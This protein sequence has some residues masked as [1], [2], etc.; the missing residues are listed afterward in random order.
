MPFTEYDFSNELSFSLNGRDIRI[1]NPDPT[2]LLSD[3]LRSSEIGLTGTKVACGEG[4]CGACTVM[5]SRFSMRDHRVI[6]QAINSCLRPLCSLDGM[7]VTTIEHAS[8]NPD[9]LSPI[10]VTLAQGNG[11]QCGFCTPGMVMSAH[12]LF[13]S[14][15]QA[16]EQAIEDSL[17]GHICRCTGYRPILQAFRSFGSDFVSGKHYTSNFGCSPLDSPPTADGHR[18]VYLRVFSASDN[19][20]RPLNFTSATHRWIRPIHLQDALELKGHYAADQLVKLVVGNTSLGIYKCDHF[21]VFLDISHIPELQVLQLEPNG[22][23][24]GGTVTLEDLKQFCDVTISSHDDAAVQ[25]LRALSKHLGQIANV[26]VRNIG[27][28]AGNLW[29]TRE[30][31]STD[32]PFP[33]DLDTVL[34]TLGTKVTVASRSYQGDRADFLLEQLPSCEK[35]PKDAILVSLFIPFTVDGELVRT[36]KVATRYQNA[37]A[38]VNAGFRVRLDAQRHVRDIVLA[39][40]GIA[41]Q[42]IR[43]SRTEKFLKEKSWRKELFYSAISVLHSELSE[44]VANFHGSSFFPGAYRRTLATNLFFR[45]FLIVLKDLLKVELPV[46]LQSAC[47]DDNRPLSRARQC[48][49]VD[50]TFAPVGEPFTNHSAFLQVAGRAKYTQDIQLPTGGLYASVVLSKRAKA[51]FYFPKQLADFCANIRSVFPRVIDFITADDVPG[52]NL[53]G[54]GRDEQLFARDEVKFV[55]Q[56]IGIVVAGNMSEARSAASWV[57]EMIQYRKSG[58]ERAVFTIADALAEP[59]GTG[60]FQ[61]NDATSLIPQMIR[62]GSDEAWLDSPHELSPE[63]RTIYGEQSCGGQAQF[64]MET[65]TCLA[66][67]IEQ[68]EITLYSSTQSPVNDQAMTALA[69]GIPMAKVQVEVRR[70]GGGFGGKQFRAGFTSAMTAVAA[71]KLRAPVFLALNRNEDMRMVG[72]RHPFIGKYVLDVTMNG[73]LKAFKIDLVSNGG[74]TL[75]CSF[76]VMNL[77]QQHADCCYFVPTFKTTGRVVRTNLASNTAMR[78]FGV[79]QTTLLVESAIEHAAHEIGVS[80]EELRRKNFYKMSR[81]KAHQTTHFGEGLRFCNIAEIWDSL[82]DDCNFVR[83]TR[84]V[85]EFNRS[86]RWRKRGISAIPLKFGIGFQPRMMDQATA[87]INVFAAD[88]SVL[89]QHGGVEMGQGLNTKIL[90]IASETLRIPVKRITIGD[91]WTGAVPNATATAASISS[92]LHGGAVRSACLI[93]RH[94]LETFCKKQGI[95]DWTN[96]WA[97]LWPS[98]VSGAYAARVDL[99]AEAHYKT[100]YIGDVEF[101]HQYGRAFHYFTY[102]AS[103]SEVEIDALTGATSVIRSD[104]LYDAGRSLNP[105][106]DVGQIEG[107]FVQGIGLMLTEDL[108]FLNDGDLFSDGTWTYKPPC[109][110]TIPVDFRVSLHYASRYDPATSDQDFS[111]VL[112]SKGI[113]EPGLVLATSVFFAV[114]HAI[115]ECRRDAGHTDW[116]E[117]S[118]PATVMQ[119]QKHCDTKLEFLRIP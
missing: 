70:I 2:V 67:P 53:Q 96:K 13:A 45:F 23:R 84:E 63:S 85:E 37:H 19:R 111:A 87:F 72:K 65:Q 6:H 116:F 118:A 7:H 18:S 91:T 112:G 103:C 66:V 81:H 59:S 41:K 94:R 90:Q 74:A 51:Q 114:R 57:S 49:T 102:S 73:I 100:P 32:T 119:V 101:P 55:G 8:G 99:S 104:I 108:Q 4:G 95:L 15:P 39:F 48:V 88:G 107:G 92:D 50:R 61:N 27:S 34:I 89:V 64:Y 109:S 46:S 78:S 83:R 69:L 117:M 60:L 14:D 42:T 21:D 11:S 82:L 31:S 10:Q 68:Q 54:L 47:I 75:D 30:K 20:A 76:P 16:N 71:W 86:S 33:S 62:S 52:T 79:V 26:E 43:A 97:E 105:C 40:G 93:L 29:M 110:K 35:L 113:G 58:D 115:A 98:I 36:F 22:L 25:G 3:F 28:L 24:A 77:A 106:I 38:I 56:V 80:P 5:L 9:L 17:D 1:K 44:S 12:C